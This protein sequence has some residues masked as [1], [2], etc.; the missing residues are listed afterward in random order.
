MKK[1]LAIGIAGALAAG[2]SLAA[3]AQGNATNE[4]STAHAHALMAQNAKTLAEAHAHLQHVVNCLV[5]PKGT[6][7]DSKAEDPCKGQGNGAIPDSASNQA[8]QSKLQSALSDAQAG[9]KADSLAGVQQDAGKAAATLQDTGTPA[10]KASG[11][12]SW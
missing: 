9:L 5:G 10:K 8:K 4:V 6:G 3:F 2:L 1:L 7:F 12:Y 11:G